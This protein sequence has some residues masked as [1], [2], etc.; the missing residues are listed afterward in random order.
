MLSYTDECG[1][2]INHTQT[3][4]IGMIPNINWITALPTNVTIN[5]GDPVPV[6]IT[7]EYSNNAIGDLCLDEGFLAP[8]ES[9]TLVSCGDQ[10]IREW[11]VTTT[12]G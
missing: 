3:I 2:P 11:E 6:A 4:N 5:C 1:N 8:T 9:G 7:L 12:C 10:I